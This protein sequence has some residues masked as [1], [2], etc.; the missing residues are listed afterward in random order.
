MHKLRYLSVLLL[1]CLAGMATTVVAQE[2]NEGQQSTPTQHMRGHGQFDPAKRTER[3]T[4]QLGL[5]ADQQAKVLDTFK[6]EQSQME[7]LRSDSSVSQD[8]RRAKMMDIHKSTN[9]QVRSV[10][11]QDQQKKWDEMQS[12]REQWQE[13]HHDGQKPPSQPDSSDQNK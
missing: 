4:K 2:N 10:L 11:N 9:D 3:L 1:F 5:S 12:R 8:D 7:A 6:S 13:H